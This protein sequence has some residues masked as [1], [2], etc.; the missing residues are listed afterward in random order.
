MSDDKRDDRE[1]LAKLIAEPAVLLVGPT[2]GPTHLRE[3]V[4]AASRRG[5]PLVI[6]GT[7]GSSDYL[8]AG[9]DTRR[10]WPV[11]VRTEHQ[12][13]RGD[14]PSAQATRRDDDADEEME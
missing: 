7:S 12:A 11:N 8:R 2:R 4:L 6:I 14:L 13:A 1:I 5:K 9:N 3:A 10:F